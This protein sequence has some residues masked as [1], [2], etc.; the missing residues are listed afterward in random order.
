MKTDKSEFVLLGDFNVNFIDTKVNNDKAKK[1]KLLKVTNS[2]HLDQQINTPTRITEKSSTLIVHLLFTYTS[3]RVI[4]KGIISSPLS[5]HCL[6]FCVMKSGVPKAP[7]RT[8]ECRSYKHYSKQEFLKDL[9]DIDWDQV[10]NKEDIDSA[11]GCWNKLFTNV[12]DSHA[13]IRKSRIKGVHSPWM[14]A[15]LSEAMHQ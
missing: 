12:A 14:N 3:H 8:I 10:L 4:D 15:R 9:R 1:R 2:H 6:I 5:D 13:P 11:V 7:G